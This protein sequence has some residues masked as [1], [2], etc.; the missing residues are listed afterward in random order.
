MVLQGFPRE[1]VHE[2]LTG[3]AEDKSFS[4]KMRLKFERCLHGEF[5]RSF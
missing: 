3:L 2:K 4:P 1:L 5:R